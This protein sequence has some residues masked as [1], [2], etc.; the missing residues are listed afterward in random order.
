[1]AGTGRGATGGWHGNALLVDE[2]NRNPPA[3]NGG[4]SSET[5]SD[6]ERGGSQKEDRFRK[7]GMAVMK[8]HRAAEPQAKRREAGHSGRHGRYEKP[9]ITD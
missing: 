4:K 9:D 8:L 7:G 3:G 2:K 1:L 6:R 5:I